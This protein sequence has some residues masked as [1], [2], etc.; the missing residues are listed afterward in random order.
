LHE[1]QRKAAK[2]RQSGDFRQLAFSLLVNIL[3][4]RVLPSVVLDY[5][6]A[7][8]QLVGQFQPLIGLQRREVV[9][10]ANHSAELQRDW[11]ADGEKSHENNEIE[12]DIDA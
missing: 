3:F 12:R 5:S 10:H 4:E 8:K 11:Q 6:N 9:Q 7:L 1:R 2:E